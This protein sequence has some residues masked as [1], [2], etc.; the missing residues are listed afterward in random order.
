MIPGPI[1][2]MMAK[3]RPTSA[4][5]ERREGGAAR[6][7]DGG[8][9]EEGGDGERA[10]EVALR[11]TLQQRV[12]G[13]ELDPGRAGRREAREDKAREQTRAEGEVLAGERK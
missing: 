11:P 12:Q 1:A 13:L 8:A 2:K 4:A 3:T 6:K 5:H 9:D 10:A 7:T